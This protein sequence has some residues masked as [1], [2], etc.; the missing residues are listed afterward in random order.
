[1]ISFVAPKRHSMVPADSFDRAPIELGLQRVNP[2]DFDSS[3]MS[4][5]MMSGGAAA[6]SL[7]QGITSVSK[8][9]LYEFNAKCKDF[10]S[11]IPAKLSY[12]NLKSHADI[13]QENDKLVKEVGRFLNENIPLIRTLCPSRHIK[14]DLIRVQATKHLLHIKENI[15]KCDSLYT[16][17]LIHLINKFIYP[18]QYPLGIFTPTYPQPI[19]V[20]INMTILLGS[21]S[22]E[23]SDE[24]AN[25]MKLIREF[26]NISE[27]ERYKLIAKWINNNEIPLIKLNLHLEEIE[28]LAPHLEYLDSTGMFR[29]NI[30]D[31]ELSE[32]LSRF[33]KLTTLIIK[34]LTYVTKLP[35]MNKL[36]TLDCSNCYD[37]A[38][39]PELPSLL[40]LNCSFCEL[41][42]QLPE[43][44]FITTLNC[45]HC[46]QL[47]QLPELPFVTV[48]E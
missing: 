37:L 39:L 26:P 45:S 3:Q 44:R 14:D 28:G 19:E 9:T 27:V 31:K 36:R 41:L 1:M 16:E 33:P 48:L 23:T 6:S 10:S 21:L 25:S 43:L 30:S 38:E 34:K 20:A 13:N 42:T 11:Y 12:L 40:N 8:K 4:H 2:Q 17:Q 18:Q 5:A 22:S 29:K 32:Q 15:Q 7:D 35:E 47:T 46:N 24:I